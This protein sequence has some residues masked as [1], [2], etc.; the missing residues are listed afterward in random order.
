MMLTSNE[1]TRVKVL[2][3][4]QRRGVLSEAEG[5]ELRALIGRE[6]PAEAQS[7]PLER[8][9]LLGLG[10]MAAWHLFPEQFPDSV[11]HAA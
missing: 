4:F 9:V 8:L 2:I 1:R 3:G 11:E 5:R 10:M 7:L 6:Y